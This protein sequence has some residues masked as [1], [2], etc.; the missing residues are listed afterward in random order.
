MQSHWVTGAQEDIRCCALEDFPGSD[1]DGQRP[2]EGICE[3]RPEPA[4]ASQLLARILSVLEGLEDDVSIATK[5]EEV[6]DVLPLSGADNLEMTAP[7]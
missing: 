5:S 6:G 7:L 4:L 3:C 2:L 1:R